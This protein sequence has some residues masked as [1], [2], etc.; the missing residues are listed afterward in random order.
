MAFNILSLKKKKTFMITAFC[1]GCYSVLFSESSNNNTENKNNA[2]EENVVEINLNTQEITSNQGL[3]LNYANVKFK[4]KD[5]KRGEDGSFSFDKPITAR[6][7]DTQAKFFFEAQDGFLSSG[8]NDGTFNSTYGYFDVS[9][10]TGAEY[11][12][13]RIFFGGNKMDYKNKNILITDAWFTTD[14]KVRLSKNP[15]DADY[16]LRV[17]TLL[18]EPKKQMT[19]NWIGFSRIP[20]GFPWY[21]LNIRENSKVPLFFRIGNNVDYGFWTDMGYL[22][23]NQDDK[24]VGGI[25]PKFSD[26]IGVMIGRWENW[27]KTDNLGTFKLNIDDWVIYKKYK[28]T[29]NRYKFTGL[30]EYST[31]YGTSFLEITEST[32]NMMPSVNSLIKEYNASKTWEK[33]GVKPIDPSDNMQLYS[34]NTNLKEMGN[35]KD[36]SL[37]SRVNLVSNKETYDLLAFEA[38]SNSVAT[39]NYSLY[40]V[41][42]DFS[43]GAEV[44]LFKEKLNEQKIG[45]YYKQLD[46]FTPGKTAKSYGEAY[47]GKI[48]EKDYKID[49]SYDKDS[50]DKWR[51]LT[52]IENYT[53]RT[54]VSYKNSN[55]PLGEGTTAREGTYT[56]TTVPEYEI[57]NSEKTKAIVGDYTVWDWAGLGIKLGGN[58]DVKK[59]KLS[60]YKDL[61][62]TSI[63]GNTRDQ[64]LNRYTDTIYENN[65]EA[66]GFTTFGFP[67]TFLTFGGG[68]TKTELQDRK[69][70]YN[71]NIYAEGI[72]YKKYS[73]DSDFADVLVT[74]T[75]IPVGI[76]KVAVD[77]GG[78]ADKYNKKYV[79]GI[80]EK[81]LLDESLRYN[82]NIILDS[83]IFDNKDGKTSNSLKFSYQDY[84]KENEILKGKSNFM[85]F[86]EKFELKKS[87]SYFNYGGNYDIIN[88]ATNNL[89]DKNILKNTVKF[90][91]LKTQSGELFYNE[92]K[93]FTYENIKKIKTN[94]LLVRKYG[95]NYNFW[96]NTIGYS[97]DELISNIDGMKDGANDSVETV[98]AATYKYG[99]NFL[100]GDR[101]SLTYT[102]GENFRENFFTNKVELGIKK[103]A[104]VISFYDKGTRYDNSYSVTYGVNDYSAGSPYST[105]TFTLGYSFLDKKMDE[106]Y[107]RDYA[108]REYDKDLEDVT[109]EDMKNIV[110][111]IRK[112]SEQ[113]SLIDSGAIKQYFSQYYNWKN[114]L[115]FSGEY[116][117]KLSLNIS[118]EPNEKKYKETNNFV[119]S[120]Q[121]ASATLT[122]TQRRI[123]VGYAY[124]R[125]VPNTSKWDESTNEQ[126]TVALNMKVGKPSEGYSLTAYGK[127]NLN[128]YSEPKAIK[129]VYGLEVGKE[130]GYYEISVAYVRDYNY[131][132]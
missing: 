33:L 57:Y 9:A 18:I 25:A 7:S 2:T 61:T 41:A 72:S 48:F 10:L 112:K 15:N 118:M 34:L 11:P 24:Y 125:S 121:N 116:N 63:I 131:E 6:S 110:S 113:T 109:E 103:Q 73:T 99:Y 50:G 58:Y 43:T 31:K 54:P 78:R 26:K 65:L 95:G 67:T 3:E 76:G 86:S 104:Y 101:L 120:L 119:E 70:N 127:F 20:G 53:G 96:Q 79:T 132:S 38:T 55:M 81:N 17:K 77:I 114:P 5:A 117:R 4:I 129:K 97:M 60:L 52:F 27:Y 91:F 69:G 108:S 83:I 32:N 56:L 123:G 62:R 90:K 36:I 80:D 98:K 68:R 28:D 42:G 74:Q 115:A 126:H 12:N 128:W 39:N 1:L 88:S 35:Q 21:R 23:G 106:Y 51:A 84:Q 37:M 47:G 66:R 71:Y 87:D 124:T 30:H 102:Q 45:G 130:M 14:S 111:F 13:N 94:D 82:G 89:S 46:S 64:E 40:G 107:L 85:K 19:L 93:R 29:Q 92:E 75:N 49:F 100:A 105:Q 44:S 122:Y 59:E 22:Y 16:Y 8:G